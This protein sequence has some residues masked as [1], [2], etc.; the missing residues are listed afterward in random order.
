VL[1]RMP[2][3]TLGPLIS[4]QFFQEGVVPV[5]GILPVLWTCAEVSFT[6]VT[7]VD[8]HR[9]PSCA[10]LPQTQKLST[11][12]L[13]V[14]TLCPLYRPEQGNI[15]CREYIHLTQK[16]TIFGS[17]VGNLFKKQFRKTPTLVARG[18]VWI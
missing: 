8:K 2:K 15:V 7:R 9:L 3:L 14:C 10:F 11:F 18:H 12:V 17:G 6:H 5:P 1:T 4:T 16:L 13:C